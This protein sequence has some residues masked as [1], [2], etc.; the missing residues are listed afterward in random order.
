MEFEIAAK[1]A[2]RS[3]SIGL[4]AQGAR[5]V[6]IASAIGLSFP[7]WLM[8]RSCALRVSSQISG[9]DCRNY[10]PGIGVCTVFWSAGPHAPKNFQAARATAVRPVMVRKEVLT[11]NLSIKMNPP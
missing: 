9:I 3:L 10:N 2:S 7:Q 6:G 1:I 4:G 5:M 8:K 11:R